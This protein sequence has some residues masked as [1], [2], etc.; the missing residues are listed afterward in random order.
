MGIEMAYVNRRVGRGSVI[1]LRVAT[2]ALVSLTISAWL[3]ALWFI[4]QRNASRDFTYTVTAV[5]PGQSEDHPFGVE[6]CCDHPGFSFRRPPGL[7]IGDEIVAH[8][9]RAGQ[10]LGWSHEGQ[11]T[12]RLE[13]PSKA[14]FFLPL[15]PAVVLSAVTVYVSLGE[16]RPRE[17]TE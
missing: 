9:D 1:T 5:V 17:K 6:V 12:S 13:Q 4:G 10:Y 2:L 14:V 16:R 7:A 11:L 8:Y 15:G 3:F